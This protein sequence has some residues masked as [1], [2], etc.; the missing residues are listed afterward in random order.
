[1]PGLATCKLF[2]CSDYEYFLN[3]CGLNVSILLHIVIF[4]P[5][6]ENSIIQGAPSNVMVV[7][8]I[9]VNSIVFSIFIS[10]EPDE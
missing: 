2:Y 3:I 8:S 10:R 6:Y 4:M 1:M 5:V 7:F 9:I